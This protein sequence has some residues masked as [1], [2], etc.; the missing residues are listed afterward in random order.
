LSDFD[1]DHISVCICT[2]KRPALLAHA[3]DGVTAQATAQAFSFEVVV[4]DNDSR[5][6]AERT[7]RLFQSRSNIKAIYDCEPEQNIAL[8]RNRAIRNASGNLIA[9]IDDDEYPGREW[10]LQLYKTLQNSNAH[11][12]LGPVVPEFPPGA[13]VWLEKGNFFDRR[14]LLTGTKITNRDARTGNVLFRRDILYEGENWFDPA[15]GRTGGEDSDFFQRQSDHGRFFVWCDEAV[16]YEIVLPERWKSSFHLK[17]YF[18][19]G[20][21]NARFV[22][23]GKMPFGSGVAKNLLA[24]WGSM[25]SLPAAF[26]FGKH[27]LMRVAIKLAFSAGFLVALSG[28]SRLQY[29]D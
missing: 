9:F 16:V 29:R 23:S 27:V 11:G 24:F 22:R 17:K 12:V 10:L 2:Y 26:L 3:L 20:T 1:S 6:S 25:V 4:V 28:S 15:F 13:P 7:V 18:R 14:R 21:N 19:I 5:R 8:T